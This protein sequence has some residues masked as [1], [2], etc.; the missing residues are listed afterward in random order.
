MTERNNKNFFKQA[1][2]EEIWTKK[3]KAKSDKTIYDT[4]D[5]VANTLFKDDKDN[6]DRLKKLL[7]ENKFL[8]AGRILSNAGDPTKPIASLI[9][10]LVM[11]QIPDSM[12]G[13]MS[14]AREA[15]VSLQR[16]NGVGYDF[17][18]IRPCGAAVSGMGADTS[19]PIP[20]MKIYNTMAETIMSAGGRRSAQMGVMDIH[21]PDIVDF[22]TAKREDGVLTQFNLSINVTDDFMDQ[23]LKYKE[24]GLKKYEKWR[25]WFW[26][27]MKGGSKKSRDLKYRESAVIYAGELPFDKKHRESKYFRFDTSHVE[28]EYC[29]CEF[30]DIFT[31]EYSDEI[32]I[33][34]LWNIVM[35]STYEYAEPGVLFLDR[36]NEMNILSGSENI[37]ATNPCVTGDT[38]VAVADSRRSVTMKEL[39]DIG[40]DVMVHAYDNDA[41]K[42]VVKKMRHPRLTGDNVDI[43]KVT[44][45]SGDTIDVTGNH[46]FKMR[47]GKY[48]STDS[49]VNGDSLFISN[50]IMDTYDHIVYG[51]DVPNK[52]KYTWLTTHGNQPI[53]DHRLIY[54]AVHGP[55]PKGMVI[56]HM[57]L[58]NTNNEISNLQLMTN[59]DHIKLHAEF[60]KG[61]NNP[62][63]AVLAD[64]K[65][66]SAYVKNMSK[67]TSGLLNGRS[68]GISNDDL[69]KIT[70]VL[71]A[72]LGRMFSTGEFRSFAKYKNIPYTMNTKFRKS[73]F[74]SFSDF[75]KSCAVLAGVYDE[76]DENID[77]KTLK[78][79][80]TAKENGY[81]VKLVKGSRYLAVHVSKVCEGCGSVYWVDYFKREQ[82]FCGL[83]CS[84]KYLSKKDSWRA[85]L[86]AAQCR[87]ARD[88][89]SK[90]TEDQ[91]V[92]YNDL[93]L[94]LNR[95]PKRTEWESECKENNIPSRLGSSSPFNTFKELKDAASK[96]NHRVVSVEVVRRDDVYNGTVD[97]VHN[98]F[99]VLNN[100][101][102][103]N[104]VLIN[105]MQ[106]GEQPL[107]PNGACLLGSMN[108][109]QYVIK[110]KTDGK[111][112]FKF[113]TFIS[114]VILA[115]ET[116]DNVVEFN[117]LGLDA[118][119]HEITT[120]RRH[121]L[122]FTGLGTMMHMM[123]I[124]Y[125]S[126]ESVEITEAITYCLAL[127]SLWA[128]VHLGGIKGEFETSTG[129]DTLDIFSH[130]KYYEKLMTFDID[131]NKHL[132]SSNN[133]IP[134]YKKYINNN[135]KTNGLR[136]SHATSIA[137]AGTISFISNNISNGIEPPF[138][139]S[140]NRNVTD[141][142]NAKMKKTERVMDYAYMVSRSES[143]L[144]DE[145]FDKW[146][147]E[148]HKFA[149]DITPLEHVKVQAAA[150]QFIDSACSKTTN[151]PTDMKFEDFQGVYIAGYK[152][153]L[154]GLT[155]FRFNPDS[156][157]AILVTDK[158]MD[159]MLIEFTLE[160]G[161]TT[162]LK[163][164]D[165]VMYDGNELS[166]YNVYDMLKF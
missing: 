101:D 65:R 20:F 91:L 37:R 132:N 80:Y 3:Y 90:R 128:N 2:S 153:G 166:A 44:F 155:T 1:V 144:S 137:P 74:P 9:N 70:S 6:C 61:S 43:Y 152:S 99:T 159:S 112:Y 59:E 103:D 18:S 57:D 121:G 34:Q 84:N 116:L 114:D 148:N 50:R 151:C 30:D 162:T 54:E 160:D 35:R 46:E 22:I 71:S 33:G 140:Y 135:I 125:G 53:S 117:G 109:T 118:Q 145:E 64:E 21:H 28:I 41:G 23:L 15:A 55:I 48:R 25:P 19:G 31:K 106:C 60:M 82:S 142:K 10:C 96:Y 138:S 68:K 129:E 104:D 63:H 24:T 5:R 127:G 161:S 92:T 165:K 81:E 105:N 47:N 107:P 39:S 72:S 157:S 136:Y 88:N 102:S 124:D 13:I 51:K 86:S 69:V 76:G 14:I 62:I 163:G 40:D 67:A 26:R 119:I 111:Y 131:S 77:I 98:F 156:R 87:I 134:D 113:N 73:T 45:D 75:S 78:N 130:S 97:D 143:K 36:V 16:G 158:D 11:Q 95:D 108:L 141:T 139:G 110:G 147:S 52:K 7:Y 89:K 122:G 126:D 150:Q 42:H 4:F 133:I 123:G 93:K 146:Y 56:H 12:D 29:N 49:L 17:S 8:P 79:K 154:K 38:L 100:D 83:K 164:S 115:N 32:N 85:N 58:D 120:K 94:S 27:K 149:L 66:R